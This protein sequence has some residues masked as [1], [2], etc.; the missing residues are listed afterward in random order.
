MASRSTWKDG[1]VAISA[2]AIDEGARID[3]NFAADV[4][5]KGLLQN[6]G[7]LD[8]DAAQHVLEAIL[9]W[10]DADDLRRP[11]GAE[12]ADYRAAGLKYVPTNGRFE[13]A[14][15][16]QR[17]LGVTPGLMARI[18]DSITVY[19]RTAGIQSRDRLARRAARGAGY[20]GRA[21][22]YLHRRPARRARE[23]A[24]RSPAAR[25]AGFCRRALRGS[26]ASAS[27]RRCP[28]V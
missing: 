14:G 23:P 1:D 15:E 16:L 2:T 12:A 3:I 22:R 9:D 7:G 5:L 21:G 18:G 24:A 13:S 28:M 25:G 8:T 27:R 20:H 26:G 6:V 11:N 4:L 10:R 17:V 19:S